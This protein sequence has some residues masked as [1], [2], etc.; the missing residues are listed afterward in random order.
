MRIST[1][2]CFQFS[3]KWYPATHP[4]WFVN[5]IILSYRELPSSFRGSHG[6]IVYRLEAN[7]SRSVRKDSKAKAEFTLIH[8]RNLDGELM[9]PLQTA[10]CYTPELTLH[11]HKLWFSSQTPQQNMTDKKMN[12]FTSGSVA[13]DVSI[14]KTAFLQGNYDLL[15]ISHYWNIHSLHRESFYDWR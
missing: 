13:M 15:A 3:L 9:L 8:K 10:I 6:K 7:L 12:L 14:P 2:E 1:L 11:V 5:S 4:L